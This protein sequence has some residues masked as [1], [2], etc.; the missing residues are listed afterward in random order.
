MPDVEL[1]RAVTQGITTEA[2]PPLFRHPSGAPWIAGDTGGRRVVSARNRNLEVV[3]IGNAMPSLSDDRL[4]AL[5]R[6]KGSV[7]HLDGLA[8]DLAEGDVLF[9]AR[10]P[11]RMRSQAPL[12]L[13]KSLFWAG[14][15]GT[16]LISDEQLTLKR[17][18]GAQPDLDVLTSRLTDAELSH[19]FGLASVW[20]GIRGSGP[21]E[22]LDS[23]SARP[24]VHRSWWT[25]P[26][27]DASVPALADRL[28]Q[29]MRAALVRRTGAHRTLSADLSGGLD[30]TTLN[31]FLADL[32]RTPHTL[33]LS[34]A[35]IANNDHAWASRAAKEIGSEHR[36]APYSSVVP[37]L[38][39]PDT[40]SVESFPEG[41]SIAS[42]AVA[43]VTLVQS[44]MGD[45][46]ATLHLN[47]HGGDALFGPLSTMLWSLV[48][49]QEKG[50]IRKAWR[51]R[52]INRYPIG[53]T[54]RMV[55]RS[56]S[57]RQDLARIAGSTF[58]RPD[59]DIS[60]HSRWILLPKVHPALTDVAR[61]R[62][63]HMAK[64]ALDAGFD[65]FSTDRTVHQIV[66]YLTVHGNVVR[67]MNH[68]RTPYPGT[69]F[70][71]PYL[72]RAVVEAAL[73]LRI[74]D[75]AYQDPAKPLLAAAR[76]PGM[77]LDYFTRRDKGDYTAEVFEQHRTLKPTFRELFSGGSMLEDLELISPARI[78]HSIDDFSTDGR[79]YTDL[80]Y[81]AF[82]ELWLRSAREMNYSRTAH[83]KGGGDR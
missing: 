53:E 7:A 9:F 23:Q 20:S 74:G 42:V 29:S 31:F 27:P 77:S 81:L 30:S 83:A 2:G 80:V 15:D 24:P 46:G 17:I 40:G 66:Q 73:S 32:G 5:I 67:R 51:H 6:D 82:A 54:L 14:V 76:P 56:G 4:S 78:A 79:D 61:Q 13:M 62:L 18:T 8:A 21:G 16:S 1:P 10:E 49:S 70:D 58:E 3:L 71:S 45:T 57:Y 41:P 64:Q 28:R 25:P 65:H 34:S 48:H 63:R 19:P 55:A 52:V 35:N 38:L 36:V 37:F 47:G 72:D 69:Y 60:H 12:F 22:W 26:E 75:R 33:F 11:G 59:S 44:V 39:A 43:S 50:R 68:A